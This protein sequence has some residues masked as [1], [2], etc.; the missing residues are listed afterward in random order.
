LYK[1]HVL[2]VE[3][4]ARPVNNIV[5]F[6][7]V[8]MPTFEY[9]TREFT[10]L[11]TKTAPRGIDPA[12]YVRR[13][14]GVT[15]HAS[16]AMLETFE[17]ALR[18]ALVDCGAN[19]VCVSELGFPTRNMLPMR[20]AQHVARSLSEQ[21]QALIIAGSAHD[22]RTLYNT[23]YVFHP[24]GPKTGWAFHKSIS[25]ISMNEHIN[26][27]AQRRIL[28]VNTFGLRIATMICLDV[29]DYAA[30]ASLMRVADRVD[31]VLVPC[32]TKKFE[33]MADVAKVASKALPGVVALVNARV[34]DATAGPSQVASFGL[35]E[36]PEEGFRTANDAHVSILTIDH[37]KFQ[38]ARVRAK[39]S[40]DPHIDWL[41]GSRDLPRVYV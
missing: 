37:D 30:F 26:S 24:A 31:V 3:G 7:L 15:A 8:S 11:R 27:P 16:D 5:K 35:L 40:A 9:E 13:L 6:A 28:T 10:S 23:G 18:F 14:V 1:V 29:A 12:A 39:T 21:H 2:G 20:Q 32:Y 22:A 4:L 33:K 38:T 34:P 41:F 25:A 19:V 36:V 17:S